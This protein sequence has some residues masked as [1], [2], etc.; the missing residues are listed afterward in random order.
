MAVRLAFDL[1]GTLADMDAAL[2]REAE[3]L[4]GPGVSV[5]AR[6]EAPLEPDPA[7]DAA[8]AAPLQPDRPTNSAGDAAPA[9]DAKA[10][11]GR[12]PLAD[13]EMR[14]LWAHVR[15]I[16]NFWTTLEEIEPGAVAR[17]GTLALMH[18]WEVLFLTQ[19]PP[20]AGETAQRQTQRWLQAHGFDFPSVYVMNGSRGKVASALA[21]HAVVDDRP[22]NCL[23][24]AL[25]SKARA[26]LVWRGEPATV[27]PSA[28]RLGIETVFSVAEALEAL[29][30]MTARAKKGSG[31]VGRLRAAIG[32]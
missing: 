24:V 18:G 21:L 31:L 16:E 2:Q 11:G 5:R 28:A 4:F 27:P 25:D 13:H 7:I 12:R 15:G 23:D 17:L 9:P 30:Q 14:K 20:S 8:G 6:R 26:F 3:R 32:I 22:E 1:D 29:E 19:R 10:D